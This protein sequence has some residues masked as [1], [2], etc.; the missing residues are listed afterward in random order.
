MQPHEKR[1]ADMR[2]LASN[3]P[4]KQSPSEAQQ[5]VQ[6]PVRIEA[7]A[8]FPAFVWAQ[9]AAWHLERAHRAR[10]VDE[11]KHHLR[12]WVIRHAFQMRGIHSNWPE[13]AW[14]T[15]ASAITASGLHLKFCRKDVRAVC[16]YADKIA[17]GEG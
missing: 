17:R 2:G 16:A 7:L 8:E 11:I 15:F 3:P 6:T 10:S 9:S 12:G 14:A 4:E 5:Y 13:Y 1:Q